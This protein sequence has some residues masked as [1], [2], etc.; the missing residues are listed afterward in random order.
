[1]H[2][3]PQVGQLYVWGL[4]RWLL[5][6]E[7]VVRAIEGSRACGPCYAARSFVAASGPAAAATGGAP[8]LPVSFGPTG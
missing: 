8:P 5:P 6:S 7:R 3:T 2:E 4:L 1:L